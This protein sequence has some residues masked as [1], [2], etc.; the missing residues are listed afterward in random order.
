[1]GFIVPF[2]PL[3]TGAMTV[4]SVM[5][6]RSQAEDQIQSLDYQAKQSTADGQAEIG[7]GKVQAEKIR[8]AGKVQQSEARASLAAS[9]VDPDSGT[10]A[11]IN[12]H[13]AQNTEEDALN[14]ILDGT[15][16]AKRMDQQ[17]AAYRYEGRNVAD[18]STINQASTVL[19]GASQ[20]A[21]GWKTAAK[22][23]A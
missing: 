16:R 8:K 6:Q 22:S 3:I 20:V 2:I 5:G 11:T 13:I 17:A 21:S 12:R 1:M 19:S 15:N 4:L 9:G 10:S 7:Y 23:R 14:A 18:A